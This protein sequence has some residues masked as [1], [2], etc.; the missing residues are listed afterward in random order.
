M[1]STGVLL[2][3]IGLVIPSV[4]AWGTCSHNTASCGKNLLYGN[5]GWTRSELAKVVSASGLATAE[6]IRNPDNAIF[7]CATY[8]NQ[9]LF[10][11]YCK[12]Y[13]GY[14]AGYDY[15]SII[16]LTEEDAAE[17]VLSDV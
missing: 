6:A 4:R 12:G 14:G 1:K 10:V 13:C 9:I 3:P 17:E 2:I 7:Y 8:S 5:T 15:C 11:N 16:G